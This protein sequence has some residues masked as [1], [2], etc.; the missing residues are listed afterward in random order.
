MSS[1]NFMGPKAIVNGE[2]IAEYLKDA[3]HLYTHG[4]PVDS[5]IQYI[6][7]TGLQYSGVRISF[8]IPLSTSINGL[9]YFSFL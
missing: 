4:E 9:L 5:L 6:G 8:N 1:L 2:P 3:L 7:L